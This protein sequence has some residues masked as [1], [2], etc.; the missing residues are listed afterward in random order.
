MEIHCHGLVSALASRSGRFNL[1]EIS[2]GTFLL[3][4][5]KRLFVLILTGIFEVWWL[6]GT[7]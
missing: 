2:A 7:S 1:E 5:T 3:L 6:R 4:G